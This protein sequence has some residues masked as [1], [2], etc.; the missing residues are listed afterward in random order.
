MHS[1][2]RTQHGS[3]WTSSFSYFPGTL[4]SCARDQQMR[5]CHFGKEG[6]T[7][8][9][10]KHISFPVL[11]FDDGWEFCATMWTS[12]Y[13]GSLL[14]LFPTSSR[15]GSKDTGPPAR[16]LDPTEQ[17]SPTFYR[18]LRLGAT[19][20]SKTQCFKFI[21]SKNNVIFVR[22]SQGTPRKLFNK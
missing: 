12:C 21:F 20:L 13:L 14:S 5:N 15:P 10:R 2:W 9:K 4:D 6:T 17:T 16:S 11:L 8:S 19:T 22:Y 1:C 7:I 18:L 3:H